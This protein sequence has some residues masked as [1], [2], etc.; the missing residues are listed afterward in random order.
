[1]KLENIR[2]LLFKKC[3]FEKSLSFKRVVHFSV[4]KDHVIIMH[5]LCKSD[6]NKVLMWY[7]LLITYQSCPTWKSKRCLRGV[8]FHLLLWRGKYGCLLKLY[9]SVIQNGNLCHECS[10]AFC[11]H[12]K[13]RKSSIKTPAAGGLLIWGGRGLFN[14]ATTM[15]SVLYKEL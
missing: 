1:M 9:S 5:D 2:S 12:C 14:L 8:Y 7:R 4:K 10:F 13:Y 11:C 6:L 15:V 3:I